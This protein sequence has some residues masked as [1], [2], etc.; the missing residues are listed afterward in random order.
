[1]FFGFRICR[2]LLT[3]LYIA[4]TVLQ[5]EHLTL[6]LCRLKLHK[7]SV[8]K[9]MSYIHCCAFVLFLKSDRDVQMTT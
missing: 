2:L 4:R 6:N 1:M 7:F 8:I 9:G 3:F 5:H